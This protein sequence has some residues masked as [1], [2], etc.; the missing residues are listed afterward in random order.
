MA[1]RLA[2]C[3]FGG[4]YMYARAWIIHGI[5]TLN[6]KGLAVFYYFY[7]SKLTEVKQD[8]FGLFSFWVLT[9][10]L[11]SGIM[12]LSQAAQQARTSQASLYDSKRLSW[13]KI[14]LLAQR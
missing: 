6:C 2:L 7:Y 4:A 5:D 8:F 11:W 9:T 13:I 12:G 14:V 3:M 1:D 10:W